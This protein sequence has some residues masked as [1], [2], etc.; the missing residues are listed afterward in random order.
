MYP[1]ARG[2]A[3]LHPAFRRL[4][5]GRVFFVH[6]RVVQVVWLGEIRMALAALVFDLDGT[7]TN[8]DPFHFAAYAEIAG[9]YGVAVDERCFFDRMSGRTNAEICRDLFAHVD[10]AEYQTIAD[11]K[12]TLFRHLLVGKLQPIAGLHALLAWGEQRGC[13]LALVSNAPRANIVDML[14]ELNLTGKFREIVVGSE[15]ERG[16]PDPLPYLT[17]L[18]RLGISARQAVVF[19]DAVPGVLSASRAGIVT[20]GLATSFAP[21]ELKAAGATLIVPDYTAPGLLDFVG[22]VLDGR[23][24]DVRDCVGALL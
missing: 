23:Q 11:D 21:A 8:S 6:F 19:E 16:K 17:A 3:R 2:S 14:A 7:L 18:D 22:N 15:L 24:P 4:I 9:R 20:V 12:E 13:E 1:D 10:P 5:G